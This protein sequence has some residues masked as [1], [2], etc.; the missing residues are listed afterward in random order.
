MDGMNKQDKHAKILLSVIVSDKAH[1]L[2]LE[3]SFFMSCSVTWKVKVV[4]YWVYYPAS[5]ASRGVYWNQAQ[6]KF[7]LP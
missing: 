4:S 6:K 3:F 5:E 2:G 1:Y 7:A